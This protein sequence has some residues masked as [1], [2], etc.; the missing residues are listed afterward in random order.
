MAFELFGYLEKNHIFSINP[1]V[2]STRV[3]RNTHLE[4]VVG[5]GVVR[6]DDGD[7]EEE[8]VLRV[9]NPRQR[10]QHV[11]LR[12]RHLLLLQQT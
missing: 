4:L 10:V 11:H 7:G 3:K 1:A 9:R 2:T 12:R 6:G 8:L 5:H